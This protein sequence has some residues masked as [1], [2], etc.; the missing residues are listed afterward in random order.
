MTEC[1]GLG[2]R[3]VKGYHSSQTAFKSRGISMEREIV[4]NR[5][6][7]P[8]AA[9]S[10]RV[11]DDSFGHRKHNRDWLRTE[12]SGSIGTQAA[13]ED[14]A[15]EVSGHVKDTHS[16][17]AAGT[18]STAPELRVADTYGSRLLK[19]I[20]AEV[21]VLFLTFDG[22]IRSSSKISIYVYWGAFVFGIVATYLYLWRLQKVRKQLQLFISAAAFCVWVFAMGGPFSHLSW[23][24]PLYGG[25]LLPA[26][27]F[28]IPLIEA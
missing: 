27:T 16:A 26:F 24:D 19:C 11:G 12:T 25:L 15:N 9:R 22:I 6:L 21:V 14:I 20:P 23:Y 28:L 4:S 1:S 17:D 13:G 5:D 10:Q 2:K 7:L 8:H 3:S 18:E